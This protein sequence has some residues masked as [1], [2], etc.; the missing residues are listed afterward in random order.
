L[1][2]CAV[3]IVFEYIK[4]K[5]NAKGRH[6]IHSPFVYNLVDKTFKIEIPKSDLSLLNKTFRALKNNKKIINIKDFGAGSHKL[7]TS[8]SIQ[9]IFKISSS[10]GHY[11][12]ILFQL[13]NSFQPKRI[14]EFGTSLGIGTLHFHLGNPES[15]ITTIEACPETLNFTRD[16]LKNKVSNVNF[17]ESTFSDFLNQIST[18]KYDLI[19]V[20]GHHDGKATIDYIQ[21]LEKHSH[22]E[23]I[24]ILDDI[25]WSNDMFEAWNSLKNSDKYNVSIDLFRMGILI[26]RKQQVKEHFVLRGK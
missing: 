3:N 1:F 10:K 4:Y 14:L 12:K 9:Q 11:G 20:D 25:R 22:N 6:G 7:G 21:K 8:R 13:S 17:I 18:E 19:F 5:W 15:Q 23:T 16:F 2:L 24:F 26:P